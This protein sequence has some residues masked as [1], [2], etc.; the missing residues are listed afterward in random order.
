MS[1]QIMTI[2]AHARRTA[3]AAGQPV[4]MPR[5]DIAKCDG[6]EMPRCADCVRHLAPAASKQQWTVPDV[7]GGVCALFA[8][9][10]RFGHLYAPAAGVPAK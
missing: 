6:A 10:D 1:E 3:E 9:V 4:L 5:A 8:S 2:A 7:S